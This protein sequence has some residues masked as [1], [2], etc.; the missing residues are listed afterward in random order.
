MFF[1]PTAKKPKTMVIIEKFKCRELMIY[2]KQFLSDLYESNGMTARK[3]L[4]LASDSQIKLLLYLLHFISSG[5]IPLSE[6]GFQSI[7]KA[8]KG[9]FIHTNFHAKTKVKKLLKSDRKSQLEVLL[10]LSSLYRHL[11]TRLFHLPSENVG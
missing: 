5:E 7:S 1:A 11:L 2:N 9:R 8:K 6:D 3:I 10:K 4:N